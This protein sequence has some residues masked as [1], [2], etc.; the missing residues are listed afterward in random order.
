[1]SSLGRESWTLVKGCVNMITKFQEA[2][3]LRRIPI[4]VQRY[5][6][7][8]AFS[9]FLRAL[10]RKSLTRSRLDV[11][12]LCAPAIMS[13]S[14]NGDEGIAFLRK[15]RAT[16]D[17][18]RKIRVRGR[19]VRPRVHVDLTKVAD[20]SIPVAVV[21]AAEFERWSILHQVQLKPARVKHWHRRV[22]GILGE[23]GLFDLLNIQ[24]HSSARSP[25][26]IVLLRLKSGRKA[27]GQKIARLQEEL[28]DLG[29]LFDRKKYI[30]DGLSEAVSN[31][32]DHAYSVDEPG[33]PLRVSGR[34]WATSCYD[35]DTDSLRFFVYDQGVGIPRTLTDKEEWKPLL[36][37]ML[38]V[39]GAATD[40]LGL[41]KGDAEIVRAAFEVGRTRT[42]QAERGKGLDQMAGVV[43][44]VGSGYMRVISGRG[45]VSTDGKG[46]YETRLLPDQVGG[47]LIEW[48]LP[49]AALRSD[50]DG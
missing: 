44:N 15:L 4:E 43:R 17:G 45:D 2:Q 39:L 40:A 34:W 13:F 36:D 19:W 16:A 18:S 32:I 7:A 47:T 21:L 24:G 38:Q 12:T 26:K 5:R 50:E 11:T 41:T 10:T 22:Y 35:P 29:V 28:H 37:R 20:I 31:C 8:R 9:K 3:V 49:L 42:A 30:F 27:E 48:S 1:M 6:S 23:L 33:M 46:S 25:D 14:R